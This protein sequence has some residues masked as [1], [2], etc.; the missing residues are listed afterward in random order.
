MKDHKEKAIYI[1]L[2]FGRVESIHDSWLKTR[3]LDRKAKPLINLLMNIA[4]PP[5]TKIKEDYRRRL[6]W[7]RGCFSVFLFLPKL[8]I[9]QVEEYLVFAFSF[10]S[11]KIIEIKAMC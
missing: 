4:Q 8:E 9:Y 1:N 7:E 6:K 5:P 11:R 2:F 10:V 3:L